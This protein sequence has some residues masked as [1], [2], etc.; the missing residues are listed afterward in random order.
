M[1]TS[2]TKDVASKNGTL[3]SYPHDEEKRSFVIAPPNFQRIAVPL[4]G[5]APYVQH[6]FS[7]KSKGEIIRNQQAGDKR[8]N[9]TKRDPRDVEAEFAAALHVSE[10]GWY[11]IPCSAFRNAMIDACRMASYVMTRAR[12]SVFVI[13]DGIDAAEGTPLTRLIGGEPEMTIDSTR[14]ADGSPGMSIR[15][16]WR[17]WGANVRVRFDGDQFG[18]EDVMNLL[19]RA[20]VQVGVGEGRP[21]SKNSNGMGWG[22]FEII[23]EDEEA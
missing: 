20:G 11:G 15:G 6:A 19:L 10:E 5:T 3:K 13:P 8:K 22:T 1:A 17:T 23:E 18:A 2:K 16:K 21:F 9:K 7:Q 12:M 4:R 14:L